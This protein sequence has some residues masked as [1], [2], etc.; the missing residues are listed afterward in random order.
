MAYNY[1]HAR[2]DDLD[3]SQ[4]HSGSAKD[5]TKLILELSR[6]LSKQQAFK[7]AI[8]VDV[9]CFFVFYVTLMLKTF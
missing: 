7:L 6:Q 2:F 5:K 4:G 8:T 3:F 9:F 1:A